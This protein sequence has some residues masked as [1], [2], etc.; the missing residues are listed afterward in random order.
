MLVN[1]SSRSCS[2]SARDEVVGKTDHDLFPRYM[3][4]A[5]RA[6]DRR[7]L[8]ERRALEIEEDAPRRTT[9]RT[10]TSR[11]SSRCLDAT[12]K[13]YGVCGISTDISERKRAE[14]AA[15]GEQ[16]PRPPDHRHAREAFVSMD[17]DGQD[18]RPGTARRRRRSAGRPRRRSGA[19]LAETDHPGALSRGARA[20][21]AAFMRHRQGPDAQQA[22]RA[23]RAAPG[24]REFPVEMTITAVRVRG[25]FTFHAFM[26]DIS[27]RKRLEREVVRLSELRAGVLK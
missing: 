16:G 24:R 13:P 6:N 21:L 19:P 11:S 3:A 27:D 14:Q 17:E 1:R 25:G 26:H 20:G 18:H 7:V 10:P 9:A 5:F 15:E 4:D 23:D 22:R 12:G 8:K 2:T